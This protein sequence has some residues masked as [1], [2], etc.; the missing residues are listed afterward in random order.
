VKTGIADGEWI[1]VDGGLAAGDKV[2]TRGGE[3]LHDQD[4]VQIVAAPPPA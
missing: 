2:V 1:A 4:K 3:S